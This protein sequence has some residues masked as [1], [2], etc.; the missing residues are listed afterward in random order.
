MQVEAYSW[1]FVYK[2]W[3][4]LKRM[5]IPDK[6]FEESFREYIH[7]NINFDVVSDKRERED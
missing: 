6:G 2:E 5:P 3:D 1:L 7:R 4:K